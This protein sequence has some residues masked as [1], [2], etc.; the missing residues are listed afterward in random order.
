V[1][2]HDS[3]RV[4]LVAALPVVRLARGAIVRTAA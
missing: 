3:G 1:L 2:Q 4:E